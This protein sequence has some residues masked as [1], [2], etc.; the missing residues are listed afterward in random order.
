MPTGRP[1]QRVDTLARV[2]A[3]AQSENQRKNAI[4]RLKNCLPH[5]ALV[6]LLDNRQVRVFFGEDLRPDHRPDG[7]SAGP[8]QPARR[9]RRPEGK[10]ATGVSREVRRHPEACRSQEAFQRATQLHEVYGWS[11]RSGGYAPCDLAHTEH[12]RLGRHRE[13]SS[14]AS[15]EAVSPLSPETKAAWTTTA[16]QQ[17]TTRKEPAYW[18]DSLCATPLDL[19]PYVSEASLGRCCLGAVDRGTQESRPAVQVHA[20]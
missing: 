12:F 19:K 4:D 18:Y 9:W 10:R 13:S 16:A 14:V 11:P 6:D 20:A 5:A 2:S 7:C 15:D 3:K 17:Q 8:V 1:R